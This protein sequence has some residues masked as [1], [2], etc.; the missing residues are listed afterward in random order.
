MDLSVREVA[1]GLRFPEGPVALADGSVVLV[2]IARGAIT[3]VRPDGVTEVVAEP[4][5]GPNGLAVGPD[6]AL[7]VCNN[8][9]F[10]EWHELGELTVPGDTPP[11][12][13]GGSIQRVD[14]DTGA[15]TTLYTECNGVP[16]RAP[17]DLVFDRHGGFWFTDHGVRAEHEGRPGV[18]YARADGTEITAGAFGTDATNG[19]GLSPG[20]DRLYVAET[21]TGRVWMWDVVAPGVLAH[22]DDQTPS[23]GALLFDAP[24]GHLFDS[25]A[26][27]GEGHVCVATLG[28]GG[29]TVIHPDTADATHLPLPDPL[30]TNLCFGGPDRTTAYV[31]ASGTGKLWALPWPRAGLA[32]AHER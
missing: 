8:G 15:V 25:L 23:G 5:G 21:H 1:A 2:E 24:E 11:A 19:V 10:F 3:R 29:I 9:G 14:L 16:L 26:V 12:W 22:L 13:T 17:N 7:Y 6:G 31:T 4:D 27:D 28:Q 18:L 32:P 20:G 30:V